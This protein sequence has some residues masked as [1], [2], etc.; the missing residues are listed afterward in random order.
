MADLKRHLEKKFKGARRVAVLGIGS[1]LRQ[2]DAAGL[3]VLGYIRKY[4]D[5]GFFRKRVGLFNGAT[6]PENLTG[7]IKRFNP[8]AVVLID[9]ADIGQAPGT[10]LALDPGDMGK[11]VTFS[12][13]K[14]PAK[15]LIEYFRK[16]LG[17]RVV[18][19]GIQPGGLAF[20]K[21]PTK[22][23]RSAA[24]FVAKSIAGAIRATNL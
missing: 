1:E 4:A 7:E 11:G 19:I 15:V 6:A 16:S 8:S 3:L 24:R 14:M 17:C 9:S 5:P 2:D 22:D 13:H 21:N 10:V 18:T 12:T 23:A 20:G